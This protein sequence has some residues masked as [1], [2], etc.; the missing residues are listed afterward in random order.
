MAPTTARFEFSA[1]AVPISLR[2]P[3]ASASIPSKD[4]RS[5]LRKVPAG[6][7]PNSLQVPTAPLAVELLPRRSIASA[8]ASSGLSLRQASYESVSNSKSTR[9]A[10]FES[11]IVTAFFRSDSTGVDAPNPM[12]AR[13]C[14]KGTLSSVVGD[15]EV[16][17]LM[18]AQNVLCPMPFKMLG[19]SGWRGTSRWR[20]AMPGRR[21]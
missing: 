7:A 16:M 20:S 21:G 9:Q 4:H 1:G 12:L 11:E 2:V 18:D 19:R 6:F 14:R 3:E 5:C 13:E 17:Q 8:E 10:A 15:P